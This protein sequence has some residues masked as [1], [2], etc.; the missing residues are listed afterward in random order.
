MYMHDCCHSSAKTAVVDGPSNLGTQL[1]ASSRQW[2]HVILNTCLVV[3]IIK[4]TVDFILKI[5]STIYLCSEMDGKW[6]IF[7]KQLYCNVCF[8]Y[9]DFSLQVYCSLAIYALKPWSAA[10]RS[11]QMLHQMFALVEATY[12]DFESVLAKY[13]CMQMVKGSSLKW[14]KECCYGNRLIIFY[15]SFHCPA[16]WLEKSDLVYSF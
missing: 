9:G 3:Y 2:L 4:L 14:N 15:S 13:T 5:L 6:N 11:A 10:L 8:L 1:I 12:T 7:S 16:V